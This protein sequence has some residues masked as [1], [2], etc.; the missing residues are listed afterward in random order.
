MDTFEFLIF[1]LCQLQ[2]Y[3][4]ILGMKLFFPFFLLPMQLVSVSSI[5]FVKRLG[6]LCRPTPDQ[7][8]ASSD[9]GGGGSESGVPIITF[10][11]HPLKYTSIISLL[12]FPQFADMFH[13]VWR[14][15]GW[16]WRPEKLKSGRH[17]PSGYHHRFF[18]C[19]R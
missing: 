10:F 15:S 1:H 12:F 11:K 17:R 8:G 13:L 19:F 5:V 14:Y 2:I 18:L 7:L 16:F 9:F 3:F 4:Y 6:V